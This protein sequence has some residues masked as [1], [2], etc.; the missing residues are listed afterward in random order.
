M[1]PKKKNLIK[2]CTHLILLVSLELYNAVDWES[3]DNGCDLSED[4]KED[5]GD[6]LSPNSSLGSIQWLESF[7]LG[8]SL[9][10]LLNSSPTP[11]ENGSDQAPA[12]KKGS[13][14][15]KVPT[16]KKKKKVEVTT[17]KGTPITIYK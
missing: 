6:E 2:I 5:T 17:E 11:A 8:D 16:K 10:P 12:D 4:Q 15:V 3:I 9:K 13:D 7:S 14:Q 1:K